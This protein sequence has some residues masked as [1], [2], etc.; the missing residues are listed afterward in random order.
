VVAPLTCPKCGSTDAAPIVFGYPSAA[1]QTALARREIA[2]GGC[3][4]F[5]DERDPRYHCFECNTR[6]GA[7]VGRIF[8]GWDEIE[9]MWADQRSD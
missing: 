7:V 8:M 4:Y 3:R 6:W 9:A 5:G 2:L 1:D